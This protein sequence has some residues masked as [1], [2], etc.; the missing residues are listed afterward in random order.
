VNY[1]ST[2][3]RDAEACAG[4]KYTFRR[5]SEG[6]RIELRRKLAPAFARLRDLAQEREDLDATMAERLGK[7]IE[8]ITMGELTSAE[9]A[10]LARILDDQALVQECDIQPGYFGACFVRVEGLTIDGADPDAQLLRDAGP[11]DLVREITDAILAESVLTPVERENFGS[12]TTSGAQVAG[13]TTG[14]AAPPAS[15]SDST[16]EGS[17][18]ST[19]WEPA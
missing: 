2:I 17:A 4:V 12:P 14:T 18:G 5:M 3:T 13:P 19:S 7:P 16:N 8:Q 10:R 1:T 9:R 11:P 15:G 6:M